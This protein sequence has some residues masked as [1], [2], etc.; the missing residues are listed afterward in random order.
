LESELLK[1]ALFQ[2]KT[3]SMLMI[4][5]ILMKGHK[6]SRLE[7]QLLITNHGTQILNSMLNFMIQK[8]PDE[9]LNGQD[10]TS[11]ITI[12]DEDFPGTIGF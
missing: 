1:I 11:K 7:F 4:P 12:L 10:T 8:K 2:T 9:P 3:T 5:F 6:K